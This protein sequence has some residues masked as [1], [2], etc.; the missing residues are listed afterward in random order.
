MQ[1]SS[2]LTLRERC[3]AAGGASVISA[4]V[5]NPLD[6]VKVRRP[7][8]VSAMHAHQLVR[9]DC[10]CESWQNVSCLSLLSCMHC[11]RGCRHSRHWTMAPSCAWGLQ[12]LSGETGISAGCYDGHRTE[13]R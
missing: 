13:V 5:V 7:E 8:N 2:A 1:T 9:S 12:R 6:V 4:L 10:F 3:M 11:R